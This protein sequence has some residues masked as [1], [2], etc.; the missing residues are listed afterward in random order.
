MKR[1][2]LTSFVLALLLSAASTL[3]AYPCTNNPGCV[4]KDQTYRGGNDCMSDG[5]DCLTIICP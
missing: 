2:L 5:G 4:C 3:L 1:T